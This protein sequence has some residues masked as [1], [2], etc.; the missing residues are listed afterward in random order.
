M[1]ELGTGLFQRRENLV[2]FQMKSPCKLAQVV[3]PFWRNL[4]ILSSQPSSPLN[5]G[6]FSILFFRHIFLCRARLTG[7]FLLALRDRDF[8]RCCCLIFF[9]RPRAHDTTLPTPAGANG[10]HTH[11]ARR[12]GMD[13]LLP[14]LSCLALSRGQEFATAVSPSTLLRP[15]RL[16]ASKGIPKEV[17]ARR[18]RPRTTARGSRHRR[19]HQR[20]RSASA[21]RPRTL[22]CVRLV[23]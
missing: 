10:G 19:P 16:F 3:R 11:P 1:D 15:L 7:H 2:G 23:L 22:P 6:S 12:V 4:L 14:I 18:A 9:F 5:P 17:L 8:W 21:G 20:H 13:R